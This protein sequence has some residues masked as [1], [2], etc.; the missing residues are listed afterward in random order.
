MGRR[1]QAAVPGAVRGGVRRRSVRG[2]AGHGASDHRGHPRRP[3]RLRHVRPP[4]PRAPA[5]GPFTPPRAAEQESVRLGHG[6]ARPRGG[7]GVHECGARSRARGHR[8]APGDRARRPLCR[9][10]LRVPRRRHARATRQE[11]GADGH[12]GRD[13]GPA[14]GDGAARQDGRRAAH[15][16]HRCG[17]RHRHRTAPPGPCDAR[18]GQPARDLH[19]RPGHRDRAHLLRPRGPPRGRRRTS[20]C[21]TSAGRSPTRSAS[22]SPTPTSRTPDAAA[23]GRVH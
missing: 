17:H 8:G 12:H 4:G 10:G 14:P 11:L 22:T 21:R 3:R 5:H 16:L 2:A 20:S 1:R 9:D 23:D 19:R 6:R 15:A 13:A 18:A 7:L